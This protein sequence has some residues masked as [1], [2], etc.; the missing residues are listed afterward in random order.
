[1]RATESPSASRAV[2]LEPGPVEIPLLARVRVRGGHPEHVKAELV[3]RPIA[4]R[5][6]HA[7]VLTGHL[8]D[9]ALGGGQHHVHPLGQLRGGQLLRRVVAHAY[10]L[11]QRLRVPAVHDALAHD[12]GGHAHHAEG[13]EISPALRL[14][15]D[16]EAFEGHSP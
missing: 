2:S 8:P 14:S 10:Q 11:G 9:R 12:G 7:E 4:P 13:L 15:L 16:V 5:V 6:L 3:H 1:M